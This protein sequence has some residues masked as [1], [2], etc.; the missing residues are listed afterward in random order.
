VV[1]PSRGRNPLG[2]LGRLLLLP[3]DHVPLDL[4]EDRPVFAPVEVL[5]DRVRMVV[6]V[7]RLA[8]GELVAAAPPR[9]NRIAIPGFPGFDYPRDVTIVAI[10]FWLET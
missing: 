5:D 6:V 2:L 8:R 10:H 1:P 4:A 3:L 7:E 9:S